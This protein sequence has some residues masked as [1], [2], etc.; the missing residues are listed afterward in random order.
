VVLG[1]S[2]EDSKQFVAVA[3]SA[4][5]ILA[6]PESCLIPVSIPPGS[7]ALFIVLMATHLLVATILK[8]LARGETLLVHN[9]PANTVAAVLS[10]Q[11]DA[12]GIKVFYTTSSR[13]D[14]ARSHWIYADSYLRQSQLR[15]I[16]PPDVARCID[17]T[18]IEEFSN[19]FSH[20]IG[21]LPPT[22]RYE[23]VS[24]LF[25]KVTT[26]LHFT[27]R[28]EVS[29]M[30]HTTLNYA[31]E[32]LAHWPQESASSVSQ[33]NIKDLP[34]E[35]KPS[36][37][38]TVVGWDA[39]CPISIV[40]RQKGMELRPDRTYWLV[41]LSGSL[42]LSLCDWMIRNGARYLVITSRNPKIDPAWLKN[43]ERRGAI[44]RIFNR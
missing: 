34:A 17:F 15:N 37:L 35:Y 4:A 42:G 30:L 3:G 20:L 9:P 24:S 19:Q 32:Y 26:D 8:G 29:E 11:A 36:D 10:R 41:G 18:N 7:E 31:I 14:A 2:V 28:G 23:S 1:K 21:C 13:D 39:P 6:L 38:F 43:A 44:V 40:V 22:C 12:A 25:S 16:L 27:L 5:S 33:I